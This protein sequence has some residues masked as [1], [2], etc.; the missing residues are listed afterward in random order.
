MADY[1]GALLQGAVEKSKAAPSPVSSYFEGQNHGVALAMKEQELQKQRQEAEATKMQMEL[2]KGEK[3][4]AGIKR[5]ML[6]PKEMRQFV[7]EQESRNAEVMG[8]PIPKAAY[9]MATND[10]YRDTLFKGM[11]HISGLPEDQKTV[12]GLN[13]INAFGSGNVDEL[14]NYAVKGAEAQSKLM[15]ARAQLNASKTKTGLT[16]DDE[17]KIKSTYNAD[18]SV[19]RARTTVDQVNSFLDVAANPEI[20]DKQTA[21]SYVAYALGTS[22]D[23]RTGIKESEVKNLTGLDDDVFNKYKNQLIAMFNGK[24]P[25]SEKQWASAAQIMD[26]LGQRSQEILFQKQDSAIGYTGKLK[27]ATREMVFGNEPALQNFDFE[28]AFGVQRPD[29]PITARMKRQNIQNGTQT[30]QNQRPAT[31]PVKEEAFARYQR[32][33]ANDTIS[34]DKKA[35]L[36]ATMEKRFGKLPEQQAQTPPAT[37]PQE[38][39]KTPAT[40]QK[41]QAPELPKISLSNPK[42]QEIASMA[43]DA[44]KPELAK[45]YI[46]NMEALQQSTSSPGMYGSE[47]AEKF[48]LDQMHNI[49]AELKKILE[50]VSG[51]VSINVNKPAKPPKK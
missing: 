5:V 29:G 16:F 20:R 6:A 21:S 27:G 50:N 17:Q 44:G 36:T 7:I 9:S 12:E 34:E 38:A 51:T 2:A 45:A 1:F 22:Y 46:K 43:E 31:D 11:A 30:L 28:N 35:A 18:T 15:T 14:G 47:K 41:Q 23:P 37:A 4:F 19:T 25:M 42:V 39:P 48:Y 8:V 49:E 40:T 13:F 26:L 32:L 3:V 10:V 24:S 33:M